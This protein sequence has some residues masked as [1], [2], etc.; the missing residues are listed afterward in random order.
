MN[1]DE[2]L[3]T[4]ETALRG[5]LDLFESGEHGSLPLVADEDQVIAAC[6]AAAVALNPDGFD[7]GAATETGEKGTDS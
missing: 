2:A 3:E 6:A 5:M 1:R 4:L 7:L